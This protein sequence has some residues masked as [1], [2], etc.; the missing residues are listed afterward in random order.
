[1]THLRFAPL[2]CGRPVRTRGHAAPAMF[3]RVEVEKVPI[4]RLTKNLRGSD[5]EEPEGRAGGS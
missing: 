1:M 3:M 4:D 5:Q 2:S